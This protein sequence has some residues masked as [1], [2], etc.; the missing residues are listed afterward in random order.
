MATTKIL[1]NS[2]ILWAETKKV[3]IKNLNYYFESPLNNFFRLET[4]FGF[5]C[6]AYCILEVCKFFV[7][8]IIANLRNIYNLIGREEYSFDRV[9]LSVSI[10]HY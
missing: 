6:S 7:Q 8:L 4:G 2:Q 5:S 9:V 10:L 3:V 1:Y